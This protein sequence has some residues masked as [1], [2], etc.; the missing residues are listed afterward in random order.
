MKLRD[1]SF[2]SALVVALLGLLGAL[3]PREA[4]AQDR[5]TIE[6]YQR[7]N[8]IVTQ[9]LLE[10]L[11]AVIAAAT[12]EVR[13][14]VDLGPMF[15]PR[16]FDGDGVATLVQ[17]PGSEAPLLITPWTWL[18]QAES[19]EVRIGDQWRVATARHATAF[20]D[21]VEL[22]V[23]PIDATP[24]ELFDG[25][26][27]AGTVFLA[28]PL[29]AGETP[30]A[31]PG[32]LGGRAP[33]ELQH[34]RT[35]SFP[36]RHGFAMVDATGALVGITAIADPTRREGTLVLDAATIREWVVAWPRIHDSSAFGLE[37]EILP[38]TMPL[39]TGREALRP[40]PLPR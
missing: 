1:A 35:S 36:G 18:S 7:L 13:V 2:S 4:R 29:V 12:F 32:S 40:T 27:I 22:D 31:A 28:S 3:G 39:T 6:D 33:A 23:G 30:I 15:R 10:D 21:L 11:G 17:V 9:P 5:V 34:Y 24:L 37:V 16:Y 20:F 8:P 26:L 14:R 19:I 38:D 25:T